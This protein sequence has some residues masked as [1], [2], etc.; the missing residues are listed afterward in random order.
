MFLQITLHF[1]SQFCNL[2]AISKLGGDFATISKL[3][4]HFAEKWHVHRPFLKLGAFSQRGV[5]FVEQGNSR[6][7]FLS[8]K[9]ISK[10]KGDF[11][12]I[13]QLRNEGNCAANGLQPYVTLF[14]WDLPQALEDEY[15]GFLS[16]HIIN[17]F[18]DF[19]ELCFKEFGDR[20]K[21]W[22]TLNEPWSYSNGGYV[23]GNFAPGRCSKWVNGACRAGNSATEPYT[24]GHQLLLSHA[25]AVKVYKNKYQASQ[26]GKIGITLV[27]HWMVPY[28]NQKVD[29]KEARRALD[30]MLGWFM[31]PLSY[32]DYPHS[33]RKLVG[34]RLPKFTPRQSLLIKG[35]FDFLGLNYYTANYAAHVPVA[36]TVNHIAMESPSVQRDGV[37]VKG[38][39]AWSLL[40][41]Y[42]WNSGYTVR[43]GIVFVDYDHG[44]KRYPK[45]SAR[46]FKKF[47]QK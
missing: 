14:H 34:R 5:D 18:R 35:S 8:L 30:F 32:G 43:F 25:A 33:M 11:A 26:K 44:L 40:D 13:S 20:V 23:E 7:P 17:D 21:Y 47:L 2:K 28:S 6:S 42:E 45:H 46:W 12:A 38:Y 39:F 4:D 29:K 31:N 27:S 16:P 37:N 36:N 19:A 3:G 1:A 15:G 41:N 24:V 9:V 10:L 22:I